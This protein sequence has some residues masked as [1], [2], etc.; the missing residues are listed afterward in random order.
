MVVKS[1]LHNEY[2]SFY[3]IKKER[4]YFYSGIT[5]INVLKKVF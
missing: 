5:K 2:N 3:R 4:K 1:I